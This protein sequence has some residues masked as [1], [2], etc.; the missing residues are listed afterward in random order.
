[1]GGGRSIEKNQNPSA[2]LLVHDLAHAIGIVTCG[3]QA[4]WL[5]MRLVL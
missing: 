1:M 3:I 4:S 2:G 5:E